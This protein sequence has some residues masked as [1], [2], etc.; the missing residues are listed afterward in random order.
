MVGTLTH[1][2]LAWEIIRTDPRRTTAIYLATLLSFHSNEQPD[3]RILGK[4]I[5]ANF[6]EARVSDIILG[7]CH[8]QSGHPQRNDPAT[9]PS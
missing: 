5:F 2:L 9:I 6:H 8:S 4:L 1:G 7:F 3:S